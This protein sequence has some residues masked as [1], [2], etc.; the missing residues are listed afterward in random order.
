MNLKRLLKCLSKDGRYYAEIAD[1]IA[2]VYV[3]GE[4]APIALLESINDIC[5]INFRRDLAPHISS[6]LTYDITILNKDIAI[7]V[8]FMISGEKGYLYGDDASGLFFASIYNIIEFAKLKE[9]A[10]LSGAFYVVQE[11]I[12]AFGKNN[13]RINRNKR[14]WGEN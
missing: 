14:Q 12:H 2:E 5:H 10:N 13:N 8:D 4:T 6:Q 3:V 7:G 11:P 1:T 9:Q